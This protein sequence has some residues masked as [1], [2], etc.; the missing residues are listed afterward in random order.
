MTATLRDRIADGRVHVMDGAMGTMLYAKGVFVN[1]CYD[2]LNL[3]DP[4]LVRDVHEQYVRAGAEV[5]ETNTFGANPVKLSAFGLEDDTKPINRAAVEIARSAAGKRASVVGALGP[6]G[7]RIEPWGPTSRDEAEAFFERQVSGLVE[8]GVDGFILETFADLDEMHAAF[9]AVRNRS[10]LPIIA[11]MS[12]G[13]DGNTAYGTSIETVAQ[14][15]AEWDAD[16]IGLNC[17][18]G[19]AAMLDAIERLVQVTDRP[20]SAQPNAGLPRDVGNRKIYL[21]APDYMARYARRMVEAGVRYVGGCCG[22]TPEHIEKIAE[23]VVGARPRRSA[24]YVSRQVVVSAQGV[25]PLPLAQRSRYGYKLATAQ[26]IESVELLPPRG[27]DTGEILDRCRRLK[28]AGVDAVNLLDAPLQHSRMG[29]MSSAALI[30]RDVGLETVMHYTCRDRNMLGMIS[31]FLGAAATGLRN[32]LLMTGDPTSAGS[33]DFKGVF[34]ID[35]IGLTNLVY[36]LNHGLDPGNNPIG[37][38]TEFVLGVAV[39]QSAADP[40]RELRRLYWKVDAGA[41]FAISQPVFDPKTFLTFIDRVAEYDIPVIAGIWPLRSL[42]DAEFL[43]NEVPGVVVPDR[44]IDRMRR[45]Q[46]RG[47]E[48]ADAEGVAIARELLAE[49]RDAVRGV[50]ITGSSGMPERALD[51]LGR[52]VP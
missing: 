19:P 16:V 18:V 37:N 13:E 45:A 26:F 34:D 4:D 50:H 6:L 3:S 22:T 10:D 42:R 30:E 20:I 5:L 47:A 24:A 33:Y 31:D 1:V 11:Q 51:V 15:L 2:Q 38:P 49:I 23:F 7:I 44:V 40:E 17:S 39:N 36:H 48:A 9:R 14:A 41:E 43:A 35:S 27:W 29:A 12:F 8:G 21:A 52:P 25:E 46:E 28:R 32:V